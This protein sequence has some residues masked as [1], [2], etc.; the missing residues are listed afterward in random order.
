[1]NHSPVPTLYLSLSRVVGNLW[2]L[3]AIDT[4]KLAYSHDTGQ[5][6]ADSGSKIYKCILMHF[7][8][9]GGL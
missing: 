1:M 6:K 3:M 2:P 4:S 8:H 9:G 5:A 7:A